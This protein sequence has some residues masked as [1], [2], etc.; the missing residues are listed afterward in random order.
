MIGVGGPLQANVHM[1]TQQDRVDI[2]LALMFAN[3]C[4]E[5]IFKTPFTL[6][7]PCRFDRIM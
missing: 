6:E 7:I 3:Y 4:G 2:S 1:V 5:S